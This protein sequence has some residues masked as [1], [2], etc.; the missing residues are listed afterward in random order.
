M[1]IIKDKSVEV[2]FSERKH[3]VIISREIENLDAAIAKL[4]E[5]RERL[6]TDLFKADNCPNDEM[7]VLVIKQRCKVQWS[8]SRTG[9]KDVGKTY[10][11]YVLV[12]HHGDCVVAELETRDIKEKNAFLKQYPYRVEEREYNRKV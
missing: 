2:N 8:Y 4:A 11:N 3:V 7:Y 12:A 6:V 5:Y 1:I 9:N 10:T